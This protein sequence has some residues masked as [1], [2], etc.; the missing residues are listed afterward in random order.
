M[1]RL[2]R[3]SKP[4]A[5]YIDGLLID[6]GL[7]GLVA[8]NGWLSSE[9]KRDI[10]AIDELT[11]QEANIVIDRLRAIRTSMRNRDY[12]QRLEARNRRDHEEE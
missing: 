9:C 6:A 2:P 10:A 4:Q 7:S 11:P 8:R 5:R 3:C 12:L 1:E